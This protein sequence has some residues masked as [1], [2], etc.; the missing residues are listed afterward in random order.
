MTVILPHQ[1]TKTD[2]TF[3]YLVALYEKYLE[4][5]KY[6]LAKVEE[7]FLNHQEFQS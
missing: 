5:L 4:H 6:V 3:Y 1:L 7:V 2:S